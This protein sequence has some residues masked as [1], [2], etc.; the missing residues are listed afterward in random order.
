[1]PKNVLSDVKVSGNTP[2]KCLEAVLMEWLKRNASPTV[3]E[4]VHIIR[5]PPVRNERVALVLEQDYNA[6]PSH[7][8]TIHMTKCFSVPGPLKRYLLLADPAVV[9][10]NKTLVKRRPTGRSISPA[11]AQSPLVQKKS[12]RQSLSPSPSRQ[13]KP[14]RLS[15]SPSEERKPSQHFVLPSLVGCPS[16][17]RVSPRQSATPSEPTISRTSLQDHVPFKSGKYFF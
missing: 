9:G 8:G 4:L 11:C 2:Q 5:R 17:Q 10:G 13:K 15:I 12:T 16:K 14:S 7:T 3:E 6:S 1:M